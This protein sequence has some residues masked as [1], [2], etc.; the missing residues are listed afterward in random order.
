MTLPM[1]KIR[2]VVN[3]YKST[4]YDRVENVGVKVM[5]GSQETF[6]Q[7][8]VSRQ[9]RDLQ[10]STGNKICVDWSQKNP[11]WA[12]V[13]YGVFMC[14]ECFGK[15]RGLGARASRLGILGL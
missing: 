6:S 13:S 2:R 10:S 3:G 15:H 12:S 8:A 7:A 9:L 1:M 4:I 14:L 11:Q 5:T